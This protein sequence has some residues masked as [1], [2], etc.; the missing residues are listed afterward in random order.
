MGYVYAG[1]GINSRQFK[2]GCT[3]VDPARR[4][5]QHRTSNP[6]FEFYKVIQTAHPYA[7]E[8]FLKTRFAESRLANTTEWFVIE[9]D[10]VDE[11]FLALERFMH[12]HLSTSQERTV[13]DYSRQKSNGILLEPK[14]NDKEIYKRLR[15][16]KNQINCAKLEFDHWAA[17]LKYEIGVNQGIEGLITWGSETLHRIDQETLRTRYPEIWNECRKDLTVRYFRLL[18]V[19]DPTDQAK[20]QPRFD[21]I[22][23]VDL[24][25]SD[26]LVLSVRLHSARRT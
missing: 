2:I 25:Q 23:I 14:N 9:R 15:K 21:G 20:L 18:D 24:L 5:A 22:S 6:G 7:A 3:A 12:S 10:E 8:Q 17:Q 11:G 4:L 1:T 26:E 13:K 19:K 16:L